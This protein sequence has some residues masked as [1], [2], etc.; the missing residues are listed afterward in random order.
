MPTRLSDLVIV[1]EQFNAGMIQLSLTLDAFIAS[2][3][4]FI[5]PEVNAFL[6]SAIAGDSFSK[7]FLRPL[8]D[9]ESNLSSDDPA[10]AAVAKALSGGKETLVRQS[11]NESWSSMDMA[12]QLYG[13]DPLGAVQSQLAKYWTTQRQLILMNSLVGIIADNV[14]TNSSDMISDITGDGDG[15][16]TGEGY[17]DA[18]LTLGD[19]MG[20]VA[21]IGIH[22]IVYGTLLK[23]QLIDFIPDADGRETLPTYMGKRVILDDA[24]PVDTTGTPIFTSVLFGAGSVAMG[25]GAAKVPVEVDR[26][27][28]AGDGG[29]QETIFSRVELAVAP[30]GFSY[31]AGLG[32]EGQ[33]PTWAELASA[34][35]WKRQYERKRIPMAFLKTLG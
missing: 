15:K 8:G 34:A 10:V 35:N 7:R 25:N 18:L 2:G 22:S 23:Q 20:G 1:P 27:P 17:I 5:D 24:M 4:A 31:T 33:S 29:G 9:T 19:K 21:A 13:S 26:D 11:R 32:T 6:A 16:I 14:I 30:A 28:T 12:G 3:V